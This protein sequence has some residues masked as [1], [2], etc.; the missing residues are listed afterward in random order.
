MPG[1]LKDDIRGKLIG[2]GETSIHKSYYPQLRKRLEELELFHALMDHANDLIV[3]LD[4]ETGRVA[5]ANLTT[6]SRLGLTREQLAGRL[7]MELFE[8]EPGSALGAWFGSP[9][10]TNGPEDTGGVVHEVARVE[11]SGEKACFELTLS[12][13]LSGGRRFAVAVARDV[14][15]RKQ[16]DAELQQARNAIQH[17]LDAMPSMVVG[18][19]PKARVTYWNTAAIRRT[20]LSAAQAAGRP[21][22]EVF[23][24]LSQHMDAVWTALE[25][26][27]PVMRQKLTVRVDDRER[28]HDLL[29]FPLM[30]GGKVH[31]AVIRLDD[32]TEQA[33]MEELILQ[34]EKMMSLGGLAAGM[35]HEINNPL[36]GILQNVQN[37]ERRITPG[38]PLNAEAAEACGADLGMVRCYLERRKVPALLESVKEAGARAAR[39]V[40]NMLDFTRGSASGKTPMSLAELLDRSVEIASSDY[41]LK[42]KYDFRRIAIVREYDPALP[43]ALC[44]PGEI[45]QVLPNLLRNAAQALATQPDNPKPTITLRLYREEDFAV[46]EVV[47]NG[48]GMEEALSRKIFEPFFTT[49][50]PG[51]GTGL[52]LSVSYF[53]IARN[54]YGQIAVESEPGRGSRFIIRLPLYRGEGQG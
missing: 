1:E 54:H 51:E 3:L 20:G 40:A 50:A 5:D 46:I 36:A 30:D 12:A 6:C 7:F 47:D 35:A 49:K 14:T 26:G 32:V 41:D 2:F 4:A 43:Q 33:R 16:A 34:T 31:G 48:P 39:I 42:K 27:A 8:V 21:A 17:I 11:P 13:V 22:G 18:V 25:Q 9:A 19:D 23:P 28:L 15:Q 10:G 37:I 29:V 53:I 45:E 24:G 38:L 52:G 44:S